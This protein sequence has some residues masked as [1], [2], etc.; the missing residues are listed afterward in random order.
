MPRPSNGAP[1]AKAV[2][3]PAGATGA[4][5]KPAAK[6]AAGPERIDPQLAHL[7]VPI[8]SLVPDPDNARVHGDKNM[9]AIV[10]SL[11]RF[12]Q[13]SPLVVR[14]RDRKV[15]AGNGRLAA[16]KKL[17]WTRIAASFSD[18]TD[19]EFAAYAL[20]DNRTAELAAWDHEVVGRLEALLSD[21]D[22]DL[23]IGWSAEELMIL[24]ANVGNPTPGAEGGQTWQEL[25][26]GMPE[27]VQDD[28]TGAAA[29]VVHF[30]TEEDFDRFLKLVGQGRGDVR[31]KSIWYPK[32]E[33]ERFTDKRYVAAPATAPPA[34]K[35]KGG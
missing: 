26:Q 32:A 7:V 34:A 33:I 9:D 29:V 35:K 22:P 20:A 18:M 5:P 10:A 19:E 8:D 25:W 16:A 12:G 15:A 24:R 21:V 30:R 11:S 4:V 28:L 31:K 6:P 14:R 17:G 3:R 13:K 23:V 2:V 1:A 27:F